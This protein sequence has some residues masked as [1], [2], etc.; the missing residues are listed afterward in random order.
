MAWKIKWQHKAEKQFSRLPKKLQGRITRFTL[1]R[2][3][4]HPTP[5][6]LAEPMAGEFTGLWRF[7]VGDYRLI[8]DIQD[9]TITIVVMSVGHRREVY[10]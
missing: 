6:S 5:K 9:E 8:C 7:R 10:H 2:V 3:A 1:E 4:L